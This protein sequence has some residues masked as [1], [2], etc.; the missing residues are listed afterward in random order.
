MSGIKVYAL[1]CYYHS[2]GKHG[3]FPEASLVEFFQEECL[4]CKRWFNQICDIVKGEPKIRS[5]SFRKS[6]SLARYTPIE[7]DSEDLEEL[8]GWGE[9]KAMK[10]LNLKTKKKRISLSTI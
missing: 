8:N 7:I 10:S 6:L 9:R 4:G 2:V 1:A 3:R 5:K